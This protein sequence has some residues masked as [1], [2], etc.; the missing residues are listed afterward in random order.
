MLIKF[1]QTHKYT[2]IE[3]KLLDKNNAVNVSKFYRFK[4]NVYISETRYCLVTA[5][6]MVLFKQQCQKEKIIKSLP[7]TVFCLTNI[8]TIYFI[9][10]RI[11]WVIHLETFSSK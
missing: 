10:S 4:V 9:V 1:K 6:H 7:K 5:I 8:L 11:K 2:S 3:H